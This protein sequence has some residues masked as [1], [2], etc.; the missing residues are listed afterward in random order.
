MHTFGLH[1]QGPFYGAAAI[2]AAGLMAHLVVSDFGLVPAV[3]SMPDVVSAPRV[4]V[5]RVLQVDAPTPAPVVLDGLTPPGVQLPA[6]RARTPPT[7]LPTG[8]PATSVPSPLAP[9][10]TP[11]PIL[12]PTP[13]DDPGPSPSASRTNGVDPKPDTGSDP[14]RPLG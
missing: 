5:P 8:P 6:V 14:V 7:P 9:P 4:D 13:S 10:T 11:G 1:S 12:T 3:P 2:A